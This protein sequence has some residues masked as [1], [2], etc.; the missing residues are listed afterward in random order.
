MAALASEVQPLAPVLAQGRRFVGPTKASAMERRNE[1]LPEPLSP[2]MTCQPSALS[3]GTS[4]ITL[5]KE[6][7]FSIST[8]CRIMMQLRGT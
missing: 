7:T 8:L 6:R 4:H 2:K 5:C 1:D 3:A